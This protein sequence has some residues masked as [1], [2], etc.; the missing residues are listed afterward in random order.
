MYM[1]NTTHEKMKGIPLK[2]EKSG[3]R[4]NQLTSH[5]N[6]TDDASHR[7]FLKNN[8]F[9]FFSQNRLIAVS[10]HL[11]WSF[12][13]VVVDSVPADSSVSPQSQLESLLFSLILFPFF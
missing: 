1:F 11:S 12:I 4:F 9:H 8:I 2:I 10:Y 3:R 6:M 13:V 5:F 7:F